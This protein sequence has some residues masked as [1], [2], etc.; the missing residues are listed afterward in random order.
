MAKKV[1]NLSAPTNVELQKRK[2]V[3][4]EKVT[5][6]RI[7]I[8]PARE[9]VIVTLNELPG[10][11]VLYEGAEYSSKVENGILTSLL[12]DVAAKVEAGTLSTTP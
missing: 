2:E 7:V 3:E 12:A 9:K 5:I 11:R 6:E 10:R 4:L 1:V 8:V